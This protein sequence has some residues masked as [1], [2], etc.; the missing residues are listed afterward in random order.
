MFLTV[1]VL[2]VPCRL[3]GHIP[4]K[5]IRKN[6]SSPEERAYLDTAGLSAGKQLLHC[7]GY[8]L[9][10]L[11]PNEGNTACATPA[12]AS[13]AREAAGSLLSTGKVTLG[14]YTQFGPPPVSIQEGCRDGG[15]GLVGASGLVRAGGQR[16]WKGSGELGQLGVVKRQLGVYLIMGRAMRRAAMAIDVI[17]QCGKFGLDIRKKK[18]LVGR[19]LH[20]WRFQASSRQ[21]QAAQ[22]SYWQQSCCKRRVGS[23]TSC[24]PFYLCA[25]VSPSPGSFTATQLAVRAVLVVSRWLA[26]CCFGLQV[27]AA[28]S[29]LPTSPEKKTAVTLKTLQ[30]FCGWDPRVALHQPRGLDVVQSASTAGEKDG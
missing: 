26:F 28:A 4:V 11:F 17:G 23:E 6:C 2:L 5:Q 21:E 22:I 7:A 10:A 15:E 16:S 12:R 13:G 18:K 29:V 24:S 19:C 3:S 14:N 27:Y 25:P 30:C 1:S 8:C 9:A 20:P